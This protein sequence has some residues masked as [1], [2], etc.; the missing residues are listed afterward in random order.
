MGGIGVR[1]LRMD[2]KVVIR[3]VRTPP[4][5]KMKKKRDFFKKWLY[6]EEYLELEK[7]SGI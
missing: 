7:K 2:T 6:L 3:K 5:K 4:V 1:T